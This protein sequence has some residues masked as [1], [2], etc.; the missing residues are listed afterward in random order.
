M[1]SHPGYLQIIH[2][3]PNVK[4]EIPHNNNPFIVMPATKPPLNENEY[5]RR[6]FH[7]GADSNSSSSQITTETIQTSSVGTDGA[8]GQI[9]IEQF[10]KPYA[11]VN[12]RDIGTDTSLEAAIYSHGVLDQLKAKHQRNET[13]SEALKKSFD[14]C[15]DSSTAQVKQ[16]SSSGRYYTIPIYI[17][18]DIPMTVNPSY[19]YVTEALEAFQP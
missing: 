14:L 12:I 19:M 2:E 18:L 11:M 5:P 13:F 10:V 8:N 3:A 4:P 17:N 15:L 6:E 16:P 1:E 9:I 7:T